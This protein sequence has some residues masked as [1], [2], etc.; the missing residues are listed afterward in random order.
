MTLKMPNLADLPVRMPGD[1]WQPS[2]TR[3]FRRTLTH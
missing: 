1:W 2:A 3:Q